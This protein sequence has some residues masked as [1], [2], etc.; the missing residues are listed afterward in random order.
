MK[1]SQLEPIKIITLPGL[2]LLA[3]FFIVVAAF[4]GCGI[5][6]NASFK[7][8]ADRADDL[9]M[10]QISFK[11]DYSKKFQKKTGVDVGDERNY[12]VLTSK[13]DGK[14]REQVSFGYLE[15]D[16]DASL[17]VAELPILM[18]R[19]RQRTER[20]YPGYRFLQE[21]WTKV[22]NMNAYQLFFTAT[23]APMPGVEF[24]KGK[25]LGRLILLPRPDASG[26]VVITALAGKSADFDRATQVGAKGLAKTVLESFRF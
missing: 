17:K 22:G 6:N 10:P 4:T 16:G 3:S 9:G 8:T 7:M 14:L 5:S 19:Y 11:F 2:G 13:R 15:T 20:E 26:G 18:E 23:A 21:G 1:S 12:V 24:K 25:I